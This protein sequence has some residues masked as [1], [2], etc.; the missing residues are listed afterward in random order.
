GL[1]SSYRPY[2]R[3]TFDQSDPCDPRE[4]FKNTGLHARMAWPCGPTC[5][6]WPCLCGPHDLV[7]NSHALVTCL[8]GPTRPNWLHVTHTTTPYHHTIMSYAR[9]YFR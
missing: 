5:L 2:S 6:D 4:N 1:F 7:Q 8:C 9:P 3:P